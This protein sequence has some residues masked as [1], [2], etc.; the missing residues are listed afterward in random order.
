MKK[1]F[2][3]SEVEEEIEKTVE[4]PVQISSMMNRKLLKSLN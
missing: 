3:E 2:I 1:K 4:E